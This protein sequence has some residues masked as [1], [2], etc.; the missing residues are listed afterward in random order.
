MPLAVPYRP[1]VPCQ[2]ISPRLLRCFRHRRIGYVNRSGSVGSKGSIPGSGR[3]LSR[4]T[5]N[6]VVAVAARNA[7]DGFGGVTKDLP[8]IRLVGREVAAKDPAHHSRT[9]R[10]IK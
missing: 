9:P 5:P 1:F 3:H 6:H 8:A 10:I 7:G 2:V 4:V